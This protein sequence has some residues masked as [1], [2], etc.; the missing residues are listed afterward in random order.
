MVQILKYETY[1]KV[2]NNG[3]KVVTYET[4]DENILKN[5]INLLINLGIKYEVIDRTGKLPNINWNTESGIPNIHTHDKT[6]RESYMEG[7]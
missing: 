2:Y 5:T 6:L 3:G 1:Y 7:E 4:W